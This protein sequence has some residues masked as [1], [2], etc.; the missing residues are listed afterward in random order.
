MVTLV[1]AGL[2]LGGTAA[3]I[4]YY[5]RWA[6]W[7]RQE[8]Y[9][10]TLYVAAQAALTQYSVDGRLEELEKKASG[11]AS[12][13]VRNN[14]LLI[15]VT[16][17]NGT[18]VS[19]SEIWTGSTDNGQ[20]ENLYYIEGTPA[21]YRAYCSG[22]A[23]GLHELLYQLFDAYLYDKSVLAAGCVSVEFDAGAGL[24]YSVLYSDRAAEL[25]YGS[26]SETTANIANRSE[27][28]RR[29]SGNEN[30]TGLCFGYYGAKTL[31]AAVD[32]GNRRVQ[33]SHVRLNN[34]E[35][36]NLTWKLDREEDTASLQYEILI[37]DASDG[38][39]LLE[40]TLNHTSLQGEKSEEGYY[41]RLPS[42]AA[43]DGLK[44]VAAEVVSYA[45][46]TQREMGT[47]PFLAYVE[48]DLT[49][50]LVLDALDL[51][52]SEADYEAYR[53]SGEPGTLA[54]TLS[55]HRFGLESFGV[56]D[57][58]CIVQGG[59]AGFRLT[60]RRQS[61]TAHMYF[62]SYE[63]AA[64]DSGN[65]E[66]DDD[67]AVSLAAGTD[68]KNYEITNARHLYNIRFAELIAD[69]VTFAV[70][71]QEMRRANYLVT[72][73][74]AWGFGQQEEQLPEGETSILAQ[75]RVYRYGLPVR[76]EEDQ[77]IC[78]PMMTSLRHGSSLGSG[79]DEIHTIDYLYLSSDTN[80]GTGT[81]NRIYPDG[82]GTGLI[83][84]NQ[85]W[86]HDLVL[87]HVQVEGAG[88]AAAFCVYN[89]GA[90]DRLETAGGTITG[91]DCAGGI[92]AELIPC[93]FAYADYQLSELV[94]RAEVTADICAGGIGASISG[95]NRETI[96][97]TK[98]ENHGSVTA[99]EEAAG[100]IAGAG[101]DQSV[102]IEDCV[103]T[104]LIFGS[105]GAG[106]TIA[107]SGELFISRCRNYA[108]VNDGQGENSWGITG[109]S[110]AVLTDCAA[111]ADNTYPLAGEVR[112]W[113]NSCYFLNGES[114]L[115]RYAEFGISSITMTI[116][117][118]D[119]QGVL[120]EWLYEPVSEE[121]LKHLADGIPGNEVPEFDRESFCTDTLCYP[122]YTFRF[123]GTIALTEL[124]LFWLGDGTS[125]QYDIE[126][127]DAADGQWKELI[128][129]GRAQGSAE[130]TVA[131]VHTGFDVGRAGA[132]RI[133]VREAVNQERWTAVALD[134]ISLK[135]YV[136]E[137]EEESF[138]CSDQTGYT[139]RSNGMTVAK[140]GSGLLFWS[141]EAQEGTWYQSEG[142][143]AEK[144]KG[145]GTPFFADGAEEADE[146][147]P[148]SVYTVQA[149]QAGELSV[150][151]L[152]LNTEEARTDTEED[153]IRCR[154]WKKLDEELEKPEKFDCP[155][156]PPQMPSGI[157]FI[158]GQDEMTMEWQPAAYAEGYEYRLI[159]YGYEA[160]EKGNPIREADGAYRLKV[161]GTRSGQTEQT[162]LVTAYTWEGADI[163]AVGLELQAVN[164]AG[165]SEWL[166]EQSALSGVRLPEPVYHLK[167]VTIDQEECYEIV[168]DNAQE[169]RVLTGERQNLVS[170]SVSG[171]AEKKFFLGESC[172]IAGG[173]QSVRLSCKADCPGYAQSGEGTLETAL[174]SA[175][176]WIGNEG[177]F[178]A[179]LKP[180][181]S[182]AGFKG[183]D[184]TALSYQLMA[185][186]GKYAEMEL[187]ISLVTVNQ[188]LGTQSEF[189]MQ[190]RQ[191]DQQ[192][193]ETVILTGLP[194][195][196]AAES[197]Y[198]QAGI[199]VLPVSIGGGAVELGHYVKKEDAADLSA[200]AGI[201]TAEE[202]KR[203]FVT[204]DGAAVSDGNLQ[205]QPLIQGESLCEGYAIVTLPDSGYL[206]YY[207]PLLKNKELQSFSSETA[208]C[209]GI[210][211]YQLTDQERTLICP[212]QLAVNGRTESGIELEETDRVRITWDCMEGAVYTCAVKAKRS[213]QGEVVLAD[214]AK[215]ASAQNPQSVMVTID[216]IADYTE[217]NIS[218]VRA[219]VV[220]E[221]GFTVSLEARADL[222]VRIRK[223]EVIP[224]QL[225]TPEVYRLEELQEIS[226]PVWCQNEEEHWERLE[227][228]I[229]VSQNGFY[230][231]TVPG[232]EGCTGY[233]LAFVTKKKCVAIG[234]EELYYRGAL[235][236]QI[237]K[238]ET[239]RGCHIAYAV[240]TMD[241]GTAAKP[242]DEEWGLLNPDPDMGDEEAGTYFYRLP[243]YTE[244]ISGQKK[245][246]IYAWLKQINS[247]DENQRLKSIRFELLL[248]DGA[249]DSEQIF[250]AEEE[251]ALLTVRAIACEED[252]ARWLDSD[253]SSW[254]RS[255]EHSP[256]V[257]KKVSRASEPVTGFADLEA[258]ESDN[259]GYAYR[260]RLNQSEEEYLAETKQLRT[261]KDGTVTQTI[262]LLPVCWK[263]DPVSAKKEQVVLLPE[264]GYAVPYSSDDR[265]DD[266]LYDLSVRL[267]R[268]D[269]EGGPGEWSKFS[270]D[271]H[272]G[273]ADSIVLS[274]CRRLGRLTSPLVELQAELIS[275]K[276]ELIPEEK[277]QE[278]P[279]QPQE[280]SEIR[281][282][283]DA[284]W[285]DGMAQRLSWSWDTGWDKA[286]GFSVL[287]QLKDTSGKTAELTLDWRYEDW[288]EDPEVWELAH[289]ST[290]L[291]KLI[292]C[293]IEEPE[294]ASSEEPES[295]SFETDT[296]GENAEETSEE[297]ASTE[298]STSETASS[299][300]ETT[301]ETTTETP[302]AEET[303]TE[304]PAAEETT[305][306]ASA[307]EETT[308]EAPAAEETT[309]QA[310]A[311]EETTT[312]APAVEVT[313]AEASSAADAGLVRRKVILCGV[314]QEAGENEDISRQY[315]LEVS[316]VLTAER[317][318]G[319]DGTETIFFTLEFL[320]ELAAEAYTDLSGGAIILPEVTGAVV[321]MKLKEA[322][323]PYYDKI[324]SRWES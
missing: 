94:N 101:A 285:A 102:M 14:E 11:S 302:A 219:A 246:V 30:S 114:P 4:I 264:K 166:Y 142:T 45:D 229:T 215:T 187:R 127:A 10:R 239:Q 231:E 287:L 243:Y 161:L 38:R 19:V 138:Y 9:A 234:A 50:T 48:E 262:R 218:A 20:T 6:V 107:E 282:A 74:F 63:E 223:E 32:T 268:L 120:R 277:S 153:N 81:E 76:Q 265:N 34:E 143:L 8:N 136:S 118:E 115:R 85:G 272:N 208:A 306:E 57:I 145:A 242:E 80:A 164:E 293:R 2:L 82:Q 73:D 291:E 169:Y 319:E 183:T 182:R 275:V 244:C 17:E 284:L 87:D 148:V 198:R 263:T 194:E 64:P 105:S 158:A 267:C 151:P 289:G 207:S 258:E 177:L 238:D 54:H 233:E 25:S 53:R 292:L 286:E 222:T 178:D 288:R 307:A 112:E 77:R 232:E 24:V 301:K 298:E 235:M 214:S 315:T 283:S 144:E 323:Q 84:E 92:F 78:F 269:E 295:S 171:D 146:S 98:C 273:D 12:A 261:A 224:V 28:N 185:G 241:E 47:Y 16:D 168:I 175:S 179:V 93:P 221:A 276:K 18:A 126:Y 95:A 26:C 67:G 188:E 91:E 186:S 13:I 46:G 40:I 321:S 213:G 245:T 200:D 71:R 128:A 3:G 259:T 294:E 86:I 278:Q 61:N 324:E 189:C 68:V 27:S 22:S 65:G 44:R 141:E 69:N 147:A 297:N 191:C 310:P 5:Q 318:H 110:C 139:Y 248:T 59:G 176:D 317:R 33:I 43:E 58:Y 157:C 130:G 39:E 205:A 55:L 314:Y 56:E 320:Q 154:I 251:L 237:L 104:G 290:L 29:G 83:L 7:Q 270:T 281:E 190:T 299:E 316:A 165:A 155:P 133:I 156:Q 212:V 117:E 296:E 216:E 300:S 116:G 41:Y 103:N 197:C 124:A 279:T 100:I 113:T 121:L 202:L 266:Q 123:Q 152:L 96:Q 309:T 170:F 140:S 129:A 137:A 230:F 62:A 66:A 322:D 312:E 204:A 131:A 160:D 280:Q 21:D 240:S 250:A 172:L 174:P 150:S 203:L 180:D 201:W 125:Y 108:A 199:R 227:E 15:S 184:R 97:L 209:Y 134:E 167:L 206:L 52:A 42:A 173:G 225:E 106:I 210:R 257:W 51:A 99:E 88:A 163:A 111:A 60:G 159:F 249:S 255:D 220:N 23:D 162:Q 311:A 132:L 303:T 271:A 1:L 226:C 37:C 122:V 193:M 228:E 252:P 75:G 31:S 89:A 254:T 195:L 211:Q 49:V 304:T 70:S 217:L 79:E 260:I 72:A 181:G 119:C 149:V 36:L 192:T 236:F 196:P 305:T 135:G 247:V 256:Y 274:P 313:S 308:T 90:L 109:T 35:T 253:I